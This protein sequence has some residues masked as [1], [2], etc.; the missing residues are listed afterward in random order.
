M[1]VHLCG[2]VDLVPPAAVA[3]LRRML[4]GQKIMQA[5][6]VMDKSAI[7]RRWHTRRWRNT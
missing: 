7:E 4:P 2:D 3:E 1:F 5:I 6:A